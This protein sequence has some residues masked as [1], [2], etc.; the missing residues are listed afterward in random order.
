[1]TIATLASVPSTLRRTFRRKDSIPMWQDVLWKIDRGV[2][3]TIA[4]TED[5]S[6]IAS[7]YW[8]P[9]DVVGE[10][11]CCINGYQIEC[12]TSVEVSM[13]AGHQ[14]QQVLDAIR[15]HTQKTEELLTIIHCKQVQERLLK[16]LVWLSDKFARPVEQGRLL[17]LPMTHQ[18][19]AE[20]IG[21]SRVTV[22]RLL[23]RLENEGAIAR[24]HRQSI[25]LYESLSLPLV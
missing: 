1:M 10:P 22:T 3:R 5:G 20:A 25:L 6:T 8:G 14:W 13:I 7:G 2:V 12:L 18:E 15:T 16:F 9:G 23:Q 17:E 11:L 19:I 21:I 4:W 24:P